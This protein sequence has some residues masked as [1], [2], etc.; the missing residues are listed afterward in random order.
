MG[1][2]DDARDAAKDAGEKLAEAAENVK[3]AV[4]EQFESAKGKAG[5]KLD[6]AKA[7]VKVAGAEAEKAAVKAKNEAKDQLR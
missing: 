4:A 6:E 5:D 2:F 1:V 7:N 3:D